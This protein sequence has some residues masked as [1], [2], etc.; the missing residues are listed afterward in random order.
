MVLTVTK[1][2]IWRTYQNGI[3]SKTGLACG[4][5]INNELVKNCNLL[6]ASRFLGMLAALSFTVRSRCNLFTCSFCSHNAYTLIIIIIII[7][8]CRCLV[9]KGVESSAHNI[10]IL[11]P[12]YPWK[13]APLI[14]SPQQY[15]PC[16][17]LF[18]GEKKLNVTHHVKI[19]QRIQ[20]P[21]WEACLPQIWRQ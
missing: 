16:I 14:P 12:F 6:L 9:W 13:E 20:R 8:C 5:S 19:R 10:R 4:M 1:V 7:T 21:Q 2:I 3:I 18:P 17:K 15:M 11:W